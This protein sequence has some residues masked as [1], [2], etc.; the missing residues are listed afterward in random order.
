M[1]VLTVLTSLAEAKGEQISAWNE[2]QG[3]SVADYDALI[4]S[5]NANERGECDKA[6]AA[7]SALG[8][9]SIPDVVKIKLLDAVRKNKATVDGI[10]V[11]KPEALKNSDVIYIDAIKCGTDIHDALKGSALLTFIESIDGE[12]VTNANDAMA[13][14]ASL[15]AVWS[16]SLPKA[17]SCARMFSNCRSLKKVNFA[18]GSLAD[19]TS[20][21]GMFGGCSSLPSVTFP[22]GSLTK[23]TDAST[24]FSSCA[25]LTS[26]SFPEGSLAELTAAGNMFNACSSLTALTFPEGGLEKLKDGTGMFNGCTVLASLRIQAESMSGLSKADSMFYGCGSLTA[27]PLASIDLSGVTSMRN[28]YTNC[29]SMTSFNHPETVNAASFNGAFK[30]CAK[31]TSVTLGASAWREIPASAIATNCCFESCKSL[32]DVTFVGGAA[33]MADADKM[34]YNCAALKSVKGL[35]LSGL[36][37]SQSEIAESSAL[38]AAVIEQIFSRIT[39]STFYACSLLEECELSGTLYKSGINLRPCVKLSAK[40]LYTWVAALYDWAT[41]ADGKTTDD[42]DHVLY[43]T[44]AQQET[45]LAYSGDGGESGETAYTNA[46]DRGWTISE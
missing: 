39:A 32:T 22:A 37:L 9:D 46:V 11:L 30:Q 16:I 5:V 21:N 13:S 36:I 41:N 14:C 44:A 31:M 8:D 29:S 28:A 1:D 40:S 6:M 42:T 19:V 15:V 2:A 43:M 33:S 27:D 7:L 26:V 4:D 12:N 3:V 17:T 18:E 45:L 38:T 20:I 35:D 23:L 34:F 10:E 24:A 25:S